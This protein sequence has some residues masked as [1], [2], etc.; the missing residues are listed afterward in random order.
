[1]RRLMRVANRSF[2]ERQMEAIT[3]IALGLLIT[4]GCAA[5]PPATEES[6]LTA[7]VASAVA[8]PETSAV[9]EPSPTADDWQLACQIVDAGLFTSN[10]GLTLTGPDE[11]MT[12]RGDNGCT[13]TYP[14]RAMGGS[15]ALSSAVVQAADIHPSDANSA[16]VV[17]WVSSGGMIRSVYFTPDFGTA[18]FDS[19]MTDTIATRQL[20]SVNC[21]IEEPTG[22][23]V[24]PTGDGG[25]LLIQTQIPNPQLNDALTLAALERLGL[26]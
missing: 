22:M 6:A 23:R 10:T 19:S 4:S 9:G 2:P 1:M 20:G 5:Q 8:T 17:P 24:C 15:L 11:I 25:L 26:G 14:D 21:F 18:Y 13:F 12:T 3:L 16:L 7:P